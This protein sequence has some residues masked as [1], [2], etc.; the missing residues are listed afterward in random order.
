MQDDELFLDPRK[1]AK[2]FVTEALATMLHNR[3]I[4]NEQWR[5]DQQALARLGMSGKRGL[6]SLLDDD[7]DEP[8]NQ[9]S[10]GWKTRKKNA[11]AGIVSKSTQQRRARVA[12]NRRRWASGLPPAPEPSPSP[13]GWSRSL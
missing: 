11:E 9:Q 6:S 2:Q 13:T 8:L 4:E 10:R 5:K 1:L 12:A 3:R 7:D